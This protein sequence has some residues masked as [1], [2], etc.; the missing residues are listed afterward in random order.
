[1][2]AHVLH[3]C[4]CSQFLPSSRDARMTCQF[5]ICDFC[6][7]RRARG[8]HLL[9]GNLDTFVRQFVFEDGLCDFHPPLFCY[10]CAACARQY[11]KYVSGN[12]VTNLYL[13][14]VRVWERTPISIW[15][16]ADM[17]STNFSTCMFEGV[18]RNPGL[19]SPSARHKSECSAL[20]GFTRRSTL[21]ARDSHSAE[22]PALTD[23]SQ[24]C[25]RRS[26]A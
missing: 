11:F 26:V 1:M 10:F 23:E 4:V 18:P 2:T 22:C 14:N 13:F 17:R 6:K 9:L 25:A 19:S 15:C 3:T 12:A 21:S 7:L 8:H 20:T 24:F 5:S 16:T